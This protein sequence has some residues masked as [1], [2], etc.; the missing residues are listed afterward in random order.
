LR[1][2]KESVHWHF[3]SIT[4]GLDLN[5]LYRADRHRWE[6]VMDA[7]PSRRVAADGCVDDAA[8]NAAHVLEGLARRAHSLFETLKRD[9]DQAEHCG[10][11]R[12]EY[13]CERLQDCVPMAQLDN[14]AKVDF[15]AQSRAATDQPKGAARFLGRLGLPA[16][17]RQVFH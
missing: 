13:D 2:S 6:A 16:L 5:E 10:M 1:L 4:Q 3:L 15:K 11:T 12:G 14:G 17:L 9:R 8:A 7:L